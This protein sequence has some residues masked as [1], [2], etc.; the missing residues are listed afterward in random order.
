[1]AP[2]PTYY[3]SSTHI[4]FSAKHNPNPSLGQFIGFWKTENVEILEV[5]LNG[6]NNNKFGAFGGMM[7][8]AT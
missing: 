5:Q 3:C 7:A 8:W 4:F 6:L 1:M 2:A